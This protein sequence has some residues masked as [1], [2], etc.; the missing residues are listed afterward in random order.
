M[1]LF[2][3]VFL[4]ILVT[5]SPI[6]GR[7]LISN[8]G[9]E[10][11][12][13]SSTGQDSMPRFWHFSLKS[14]ISA[15]AE[16]VSGFSG[17]GAKLNITGDVSGYDAEF[18]HYVLGVDTLS[19]SGDSFLAAIKVFDADTNIRVRLYCRWQ[20]TLNAILQTDS[21]D[22]TV[23]STG[24]QELFVKSRRPDGAVKYRFQLRI[25]KRTNFQGLASVIVDDAYFGP[26][27]K[28]GEALSV[29]KK[30]FLLVKNKPDTLYLKY[31]NNGPSFI[32]TVRI[33]Y[34][35][36]VNNLTGSVMMVDTVNVGAI[37]SIAIPIV[38]NFVGVDTLVAWLEV[39]GDTIWSND[40]IYIPIEVW[41]DS[42]VAASNFNSPEDFPP[43]GWSTEILQDTFNWGWYDTCVVVNWG[44]RYLAAP[45]FEG[46][47]V[48]GYPSHEAARGS[49]ARLITNP[50]NIGSARKRVVL[51]FYMLRS[52]FLYFDYLS[53]DSLMVEYLIDGDYVPVTVVYRVDTTLVDSSASWQRYTVVIGDFPADT[54][55]SVSFRAFGEG[56]LNMFID[57]VLIFT[58]APGPEFD[59]NL[60]SDIGKFQNSDNYWVRIRPYGSPYPIEAC[61]LYYRI[62]NKSFTAVPMDSTDEETGYFYFT[63]PNDDPALD[64]SVEFYFKFFEGLPWMY[65]NRYPSTGTISYTILPVA[66][67]I[68]TSFSFGLLNSRITQGNFDFTY[69]VPVRSN[70]EICVYSVTG[71][72]VAIL[73]SG[74]KDPGYYTVKWDG[75]S[76]S[77][78]RLPSGV[79]FV[80]MVTPEK[81]FTQR[82]LIGR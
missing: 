62:L 79:Y 53:E 39:P 30:S 57:S 42:T 45:V 60:N 48:A 43:V 13:T 56:G 72:R 70:V 16:K 4:Y 17:F 18:Y 7:N 34:L 49:S 36:K 40:T 29:I 54:N 27:I 38:Y 20:D 33:K 31:R 52:K 10:V 2:S 5:I 26:T 46:R 47:G 1:R 63:I 8:P 23:D 55:I 11:W 71:Q 80:K 61:S 82:V 21:T 41:P 58:T 15:T 78:S 51:N 3:I 74:I 24:W 66:D 64:K 28:D 9:F 37:D 6:N 44:G 35:H 14:G 81:S 68:P 67:K 12:D 19:F 50:F 77:G 25:Y 22:Y 76:N 32:N 69:A 59:F 73:V 75:K 65:A